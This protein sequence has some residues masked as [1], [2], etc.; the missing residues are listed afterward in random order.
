MSI[1][2]IEIAKRQAIIDSKEEKLAKAVALRDEADALEEEAVAIDTVTLSAEIE[3]LA[4]YLPKPE[5]ENEEK[6]EA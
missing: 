5:D 2:D 4:T 6:L 1:I 3:E